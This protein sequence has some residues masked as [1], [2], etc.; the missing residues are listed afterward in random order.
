MSSAM[1]WVIVSLADHDQNHTTQQD[2]RNQLVSYFQLENYNF[3]GAVSRFRIYNNL[4]CLF[5]TLGQPMA[6]YNIIEW[7]LQL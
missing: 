2:Y 3:W 4:K 5:Y 6:V 1:V 7:H